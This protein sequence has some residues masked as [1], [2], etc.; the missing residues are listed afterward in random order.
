ML[1]R[2][3]TPCIGSCPNQLFISVNTYLQFRITSFKIVTRYPS[4]SLL[5]I[6]ILIIG[7]KCTKEA[8]SAVPNE[9]ITK[10][11]DG[12]SEITCVLKCKV[13]KT[14]VSTAF[15]KTDKANNIG[16][17]IMLSN[18]GKNYIANTNAGGRL[19]I[20]NIVLP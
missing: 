15:D 11:Y 19:H 1:H 13:S 8:I 9:D 10:T 20:H 17:C 7:E 18:G 12:V 4:M 6:S 14:C 16:R 3:R 5:T 2:V